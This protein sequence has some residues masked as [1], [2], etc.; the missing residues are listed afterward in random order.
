MENKG[1]KSIAI[2]SLEDY[3]EMILI[4]S[5][6][7]KEIRSIDLANSLNYSKA[8]ISVALKKLKEEQYIYFDEKMHIFLTESGFKVAS[9]VY[10]RH[11]ILRELLYRI[12]VSE[13]NATKDACAIEHIISEETFIA[14][15]KEL[16]K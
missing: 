16:D 1:I 2:Q 3:L 5:Q 15:K 13:P 7:K 14:I 11:I 9:K 12:G 8:S 10:E 4:L 6:T